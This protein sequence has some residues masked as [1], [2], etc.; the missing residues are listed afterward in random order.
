MSIQITDKDALIVVDV[1]NDFC[2]NGSLAV[3]GGNEIVPMINALMPRFCHCVLTQDWH[4]TD[5]VSFFD[6][7]PDKNPFETIELPYGEQVL[8]PRHCVQGT[9]GADFHPE[10]LTYYAQMIIRKGHRSKIDSYSAFL[11]ADRFTPTGLSGYLHMHGIK[12]VFIVGLATDFCVSWT[13]TDAR[14]FG[15]ECV[16]IED[17]CRAIDVDGSLKKAYA[18]W[19]KWGV[20]RITADCLV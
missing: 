15:F 17:A 3:A 12:R 14:Q 13:A 20:G 7:H 9:H 4:S 11:E 6:N 5:H 16:V 18:S 10:L 1:Q 19:E 2:P 8:W